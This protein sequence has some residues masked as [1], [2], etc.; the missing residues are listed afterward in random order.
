M[1]RVKSKVAAHRRRKKIMKLAK[2][3]RGGRSKLFCTAREAVDRARR[4]SYIHRKQ[5]KRDFRALWIQR[6]NAGVRVFGLSYSRFIDGLKKE[7]IQINRKILADMA[8][9]DPQGFE[10]LV[11]TA[12]KRL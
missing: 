6:I 5:K 10:S 4:Y 7:G 3:Y 1:P 11:N 8:V 12:R 9:N 2:G